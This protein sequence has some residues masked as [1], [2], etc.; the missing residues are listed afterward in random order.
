MCIADVWM[1]LQIQTAAEHNRR[2]N[3][4]ESVLRKLIP[5]NRSGPQPVRKEARQLKTVISST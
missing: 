4:L 5:K 3:F 2:M 1:E